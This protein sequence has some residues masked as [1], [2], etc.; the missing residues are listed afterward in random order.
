MVYCLAD[1]YFVSN[2]VHCLICK[3]SSEKPLLRITASQKCVYRG[4]G[5]EFIRRLGLL[6]G[7]LVPL[8]F[9]DIRVRAQT[10][11]YSVLCLRTNR[12]SWNTS[13]TYSR[14]LRQR[15]LG[16]SP[17]S[18]G[19]SA[20]VAEAG[21]SVPWL[22]MRLREFEM[23]HKKFRYDN[24]PISRSL[25]AKALGPDYLSANTSIAVHKLCNLENAT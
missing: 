4:K 21:A 3:W 6:C 13:S 7:V 12:D 2:A 22:Q 16:K 1:Y 14:S 20:E 11:S 8:C 17:H 24:T 19:L 5:E 23:A 15:E 10:G 9:L 18:P 25:R